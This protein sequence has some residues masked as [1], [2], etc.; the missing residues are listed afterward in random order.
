MILI[1]R[2]ESKTDES[3]LNFDNNDNSLVWIYLKDSIFSN[4][5]LTNQVEYPA[6]TIKRLNKTGWTHNTDDLIPSGQIINS[7]KKQVTEYRYYSRSFMA[8]SAKITKTDLKRLNNNQYI[9][10]IV[11]LRVLSRK[12]DIE[13]KIYEPSLTLDKNSFY[14]SSYTQLEQLNIPAIHDSGLT[15]KGVLIAICDVGFHK[16]HIVFNKILAENRLLKEYDFI[17]HDN[18]VQCETPEDT[19]FGGIQ[20]SHGTAT[21]S[22]IGAYV[23]GNCIGAAYNADFLLAKTEKLGSETRLE[24]DNLVAAVEWADS[25]GAEI[26]SISLGYR[27]FDNFEYPFSKLDGKSAR[28][29]IIINWAYK[30]GIVSI[31]AAGNSR[32]QFTDGGIVTP[33][34]AFGAITVG[35]VNDQDSI[36]GFSSHGPTFDGRIKPDI[37]AMG[38]RNYYASDYTDSAFVRGNGT[39]FAT[40]L[41]AGCVALLLEKYP[42]LTPPQ[43]LDIFRKSSDRYDNPDQIYGWGIPD[44]QKAIFEIANLKIPER[45][46]QTGQVLVFP[47]P[48][49][50]IINF[51]FTNNNKCNSNSS[52]ELKIFDLRGR[53][54]FSEK[55]HNLSIWNQEV[56]YKW[57]LK[58]NKRTSVSSGIYFIQV[59][60]ENTLITEKFIILR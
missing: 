11:P 26:I 40:P 59:E 46:I 32:G 34:D 36:A 30:R 3:S 52:I 39:S 31:V 20:S 33:G 29:S 23:P 7:I 47:N 15:G 6:A 2:G 50:E 51:I 37:C 18:N 58:N 10:K 45:E 56:D 35:A 12:P 44:M 38:Y 13:N 54:V 49:S 21:W 57:N 16:E 60:Q 17:F 9:E 28:T 55:I 8:I 5:R 42:Y 25:L 19:T 41:I 4:P 24:E 14:G 53:I 1:S 22:H 43:I 27:D 48:A